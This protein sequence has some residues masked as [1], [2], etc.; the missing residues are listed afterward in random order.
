M[1][2]LNYSTLQPAVQMGVGKQA[3]SCEK[4]PKDENTFE[5]SKIE[6]DLMS[7]AIPLP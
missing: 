3:Q 6:Q 4:F 5:K 1:L 2:E 7:T